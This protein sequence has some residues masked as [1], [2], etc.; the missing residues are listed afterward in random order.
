MVRLVPRGLRSHWSAGTSCSWRSSILPK[1]PRVQRPN[2][3]HLALLA[4]TCCRRGLLRRSR[5]KLRRGE[6]PRCGRSAP[7]CTSGSAGAAG[8]LVPECTDERVEAPRLPVTPTRHC[9]AQVTADLAPALTGR[10]DGHS[11]TRTNVLRAHAVRAWL[12]G[13]GGRP[14]VTALTV[15]VAVGSMTASMRSASS[16]S[17][18]RGG[19]SVL[20]SGSSVRAS[21]RPERCCC[22]TPGDHAVG[23]QDRVVPGLARRGS[24]RAAAAPGYRRSRG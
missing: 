15:S 5:V 12:A 11:V 14:T 7:G 2:R 4:M 16:S 1:R 13:S 10:L 18:R 21:L 19:A 8:T 20:R 17:C 22:H 3:E 24:A 23:Q 6:F 9:S